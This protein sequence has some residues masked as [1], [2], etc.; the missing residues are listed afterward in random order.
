MTRRHPAKAAMYPGFFRAAK[1]SPRF[2]AVSE[3]VRDY[4]GTLGV[5][6]ERITVVPPP[7]DLSEHTTTGAAASASG[8]RTVQRIERRNP[9]SACGNNPSRD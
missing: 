9:R 4:L 6:L 5:A 2:L 1:M 8:E 3:A 7:V